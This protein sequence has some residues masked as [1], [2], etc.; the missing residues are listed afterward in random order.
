MEYNTDEVFFYSFVSFIC[1]KWF[2]VGIKALYNA[3][4]MDLWLLGITYFGFYM[5]L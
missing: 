3:C 5:P 2:S 4:E 1:F